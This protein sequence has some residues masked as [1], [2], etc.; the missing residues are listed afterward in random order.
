MICYSQTYCVIL[1]SSAS[2][3]RLPFNFE[4]KRGRLLSVNFAASNLANLNL[5]V[6]SDERD[7]YVWYI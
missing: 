4:V 3:Y 5:S 6:K 1:Q 2:D 7:V